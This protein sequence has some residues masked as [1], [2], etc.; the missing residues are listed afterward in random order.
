MFQG[1]PVKRVLLCSDLHLTSNPRDD[2][3]W[4]LFD[5]VT[6]QHVKYQ[7]DA[8]LLLGDLT[9]A[10]DHHNS[11]LV[12]A[13]VDSL[14]GITKLGIPLH[15]LRGNHDGID[16][17]FPYFRFLSHIPNIHFYARPTTVTM[18]GQKVLML[19]HSRSPTQDWKKI[20]FTD[21]HCVFA[22]VTVSGAMAEAGVKLEGEWAAGDFNKVPVWSGDVHVPQTIRTVHYVG[23][24]YPV[25]FGDQFQPRCVLLELPSLKHTD[26][27]F[28][29]LQKL[30]V[31]VTSIKALSKVAPKKGDQVKVRVRLT[32]SDYGLWE[33]YKKDIRNWAE[34]NQVQLISTEL[35]REEQT[36]TPGQSPKAETK[37]AV[38]RPGQFRTYCRQSRTDWDLQEIGER[39]L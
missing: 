11:I 9:D 16:P 32:R 10:K 39:L 7:F 18:L 36:S 8:V 33:K 6:Q 17:Q 13:I 37:T 24:P 22:H 23:S 21:Y 12:N 2:Y 14:V 38:D 25:R 28:P 5:W 1:G 20:Q 27:F 31:E 15:V 35:F 34:E 4:G 3:R 30:M 29:T 26:L 19:P